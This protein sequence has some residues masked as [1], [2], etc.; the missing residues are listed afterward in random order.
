[1]VSYAANAFARFLLG[2]LLAGLLWQHLE[3]FAV[4]P[5]LARTQGVTV[6]MQAASAAVGL[7][8]VL[9]ACFLSVNKLAGML[10]SGIPGMA[11]GQSIGA[12]GQTVAVGAAIVGTA[13][14]AGVVGASAATGGVRAGVQAVAGLRSGS[15]TTLQEAARATFAGVQ[16]GAHGQNL[17][18]LTTLMRGGDPTRLMGAMSHVTLQQLMQGSR[19]QHD[20]TSGGARHHA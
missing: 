5:L 15:L 11:G 7:A 10:T 2:A 9:A 17:G 20:Q 16:S 14:A 12:L 1:V 3:A 4:S 13:G 6:A 19:Q 8:W 18:R